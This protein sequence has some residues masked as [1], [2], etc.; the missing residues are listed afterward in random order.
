MYFKSSLHILENKIGL[1]ERCV[2]VA[3]AK[4][5]Q[6][7]SRSVGNHHACLRGQTWR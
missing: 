5:A 6:I 3:L 7:V 2:S 4:L 1:F